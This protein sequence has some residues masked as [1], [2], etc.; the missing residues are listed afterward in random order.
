MLA[1][2]RQI[3]AEGPHPQAR[4]PCASASPTMLDARVRKCR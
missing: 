3:K 1:A 4:A 2:I